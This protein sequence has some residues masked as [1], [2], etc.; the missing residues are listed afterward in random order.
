MARI[1]PVI[2][3]SNPDHL[4]DEFNEPQIADLLQF[5]PKSLQEMIVHDLFNTVGDDILKLI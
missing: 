3:E 1:L 5:F 2:C 4:V